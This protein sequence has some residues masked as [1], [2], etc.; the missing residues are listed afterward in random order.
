MCILFF[1]A[2]GFAKLYQHRTEKDGFVTT[3]T[4]LAITSVPVPPWRASRIISSRFLRRYLCSL[5][6][7]RLF[8]VLS[9]A[10]QVYERT[11]RLP[12]ES[13]LLSLVS[14]LFTTVKNLPL[15]NFRMR[16]I[17]VL[18]FGALTVTVVLYAIDAVFCLL[19]IPF[20]YFWY[21]EW[22]EEST[23]GSRVRGASK[24]SALFLLITLALLLTGFF[25]P[26]S[27]DLTGGIDLDYLKHLL[28]Q[29][30]PF[31]VRT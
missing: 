27:H 11:G 16:N 29:N 7:L 12:N 8:R 17:K 1:F 26:I 24:Y 3:V 28:S 18:K 5:L 13:R 15:L 4:V 2:V 31:H 25:I 6:T 21:E 9:T 23:L 14:K 30:R 22:D 20:T 10:L 19:I